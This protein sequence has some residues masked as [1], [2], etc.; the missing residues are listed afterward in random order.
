MQALAKS[1]LE[2]K[3]GRKTRT[4]AQVLPMCLSSVSLPKSVFAYGED[5]C[6]FYKNFG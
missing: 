5:V 3:V 1:D 6:L 4:E 2:P